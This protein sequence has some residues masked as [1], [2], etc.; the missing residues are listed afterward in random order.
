MQRHRQGARRFHPPA[1][2]AHAQRR[3]PRHVLLANDRPTRQRPP[4]RRTA[5][6]QSPAKPTPRPNPPPKNR[7]PKPPNK[8]PWN[9]APAAPEAADAPFKPAFYSQPSL[10]SLHPPG[11]DVEQDDAID[12]LF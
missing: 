12:R 7:I 9:T 1:I 5:H 11:G 3:R 10:I 4:S 8:P 2:L 6:R